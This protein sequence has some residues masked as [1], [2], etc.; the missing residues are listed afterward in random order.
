MTVKLAGVVPLVGATESHVPPVGV[1]TLA[2]AV[3]PKFNGGSRM[4]ET[5]RFCVTVL[6]ELPSW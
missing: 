5:A 2:A 4:L 3:K 1:L 6:C